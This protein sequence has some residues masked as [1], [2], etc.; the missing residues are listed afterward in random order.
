V[1]AL[2]RLRIDDAALTAA[3]ARPDCGAI[4]SFLGTTRDHHE[5][6][7]VLRLE[8]EAYELM[9]IEAL[10]RI[11]REAVERFGVVSCAI[12]HRLGEVPA[13]EASVVVVVAAAHRGPAFDACRWAMDELKRAVPIWK[14]EHFEGG[15]AAWVEGHPLGGS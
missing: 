10:G 6:R 1:P 5:G 4:V 3:A 2:T 8:Y 9:A 7:R 14:K 11:E 15:D 12:A 13:A